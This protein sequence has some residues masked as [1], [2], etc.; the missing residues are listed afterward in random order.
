MEV[1]R[2][3]VES[4]PEQQLMHKKYRDIKME[5]FMLLFF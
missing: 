4:C 5:T 2:V 3:T 1:E